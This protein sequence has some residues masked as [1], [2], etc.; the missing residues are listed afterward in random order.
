VNVFDRLTCGLQ[1]FA[2]G[3]PD[4]WRPEECYD[5]ADLPMRCLVRA[6]CAT[7]RGDVADAARQLGAKLR[8]QHGYTAPDDVNEA[9]RRSSSAVATMRPNH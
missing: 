7:I 6:F 2:A 4:R 1:S 8:A 9:N 5:V 3:Y